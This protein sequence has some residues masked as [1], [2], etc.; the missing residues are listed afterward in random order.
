[1]VNLQVQ[2]RVGPQITELTFILAED[3]QTFDHE[4]AVEIVLGAILVSRWSIAVSPDGEMHA[5]ANL[6]KIPFEN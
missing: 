3:I 6:K 1:M 4:T 5:T 2:E